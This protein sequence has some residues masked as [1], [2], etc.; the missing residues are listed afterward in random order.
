VLEGGRGNDFL[1]GQPGTDSFDGGPGRDLIAA[2][3]G[4]AETIACGSGRDTVVLDR[5]DRPAK[6]C[7]RLVFH[8]G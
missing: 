7:E 3:D 1:N 8:P 5:K 4:R 6:D 2:K